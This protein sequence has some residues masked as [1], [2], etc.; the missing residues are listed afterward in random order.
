M[1]IRPTTIVHKA[2][3]DGR[4]TAAVLTWSLNKE[5]AEQSR[6]TSLAAVYVRI[7]LEVREHG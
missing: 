7:E 6:S 2:L 5:A 3:P 1:F 4:L